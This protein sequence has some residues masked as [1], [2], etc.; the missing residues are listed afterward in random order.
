MNA[1]QAEDMQCSIGVAQR[2]G[3]GVEK[4]RKMEGKSKQD[5]WTEAANLAGVM[6]AS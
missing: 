3:E 2:R 4:A 5:R 1:R 6:A